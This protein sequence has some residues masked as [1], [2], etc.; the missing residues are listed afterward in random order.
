MYMIEEALA[1]HSSA[2]AW[3]IPWTGSLVG[4]RV[5]HDWRDLAAAGVDYDEGRRVK[6]IWCVQ[7]L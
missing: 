6:N 4:R 3:K 5:G 7:F 1:A 2:P